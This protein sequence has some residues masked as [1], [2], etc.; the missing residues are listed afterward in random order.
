MLPLHWIPAPPMAPETRPM[1]QPGSLTA[2][3]ARSGRVTVDVRT[4]G[5]QAARADEAQALGLAHA[6]MRV[7]VREVVVRRDGKPAVL[8]RSVTTIAGVGGPWKGLRRLGRR[9]LATLV[10]TDPRIRRGPFEFTR[11]PLGSR[12]LAR[13]STFWRGG[14]PLIVMEAFVGLPWPRVAWLKR[15]RRWTVHQSA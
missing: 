2:R 11:L 8:A 10:W 13:R 7:F 9:P 12:P 3:L 4:S 6:G 14:V 15:L 1:R 5:W